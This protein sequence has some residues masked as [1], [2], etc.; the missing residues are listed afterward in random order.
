MKNLGRLTGLWL[1]L[2]GLLFGSVVAEVDSTNIL[3]GE[4]VEL[5]LK[6]DGESVKFPPLYKIGDYTVSEQG[7]QQ[8]TSII[9]GKVSKQWIKTYAFTPTR[10]VTIPPIT[11]EVDGNEEATQP[12]PIRVVVDQNSGDDDFRLEMNLSK[13][14]AYV[15]EMLE[16]VI[17]FYEKRHVKVMDM[18][19]IPPSFDDFW[20]RQVGK[21]KRYAQGNELIHELRYLYFPQKAGELEI[22]PAKIKVAVPKR[23]RDVFG[24][25]MQRPKWK[26]LVANPLEVAVKPLPQDIRLVGDFTI[27]AQ[28]D[29]TSVKR[30]EPVNLKIVVEG[31]GNIEDLQVADP[32]MEGVTRFS[33]DANVTQ[34]IENGI[35]KVRW[36]KN[37]ALIGEKSFVIPSMQIAYFDPESERVKMP[38][39]QDFSITVEGGGAAVS[40]TSDRIVTA[41]ELPKEKVS[42]GGGTASIATL[43]TVA[44]LALLAGVAAT[45][46]SLRAKAW[47]I[48]RRRPKRPT[49]KSDA[50]KLQA[51]LPYISTDGEASE[52]AERL[53][54]AILAGEKCE[55]DAKSY[56][57]LMERLKNIQ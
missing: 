44:L 12:V 49:L 39:T 28:V 8:Y 38:A 27:T 4:E 55:I 21:E 32:K 9:N 51:L 30:G 35:L 15:G 26:T 29:K 3:L 2:S 17:K 18:N 47:W 50:Q 22:E 10:S 40:S 16:L 25:V 36:E 52:W 46:G 19:F 37:Y 14:E 53:Q 45:L 57:K 7:T 13:S 5:T 56:R 33:D 54:R 24:F 11:V 1:L 41:M 20:V 6:A 48:A 31:T 43:L 42:T 34:K 23:E